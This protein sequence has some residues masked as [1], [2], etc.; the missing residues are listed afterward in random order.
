MEA[1]HLP[2]IMP[3]ASEKINS[4]KKK[5]LYL[6]YQEEELDYLVV[7]EKKSER[8]VQLITAYPVFFVSAKKDYEK[9]Y[10]NYI[11]NTKNR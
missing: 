3:E 8:R 5:R 11:N 9:D 2:T 7:L 4:K 10:Q 6:R 1:E